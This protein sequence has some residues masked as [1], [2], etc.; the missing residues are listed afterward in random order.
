MLKMFFL[1]FIFFVFFSGQSFCYEIRL[2]NQQEIQSYNYK[3]A[4]LVIDVFRD[5]PHFYDG[6]LEDEKQHLDQYFLSKNATIVVAEKNHELIGAI[7]GI[8]LGETFSNCQSFFK[9]HNIETRDMFYLGEIALKK[10]H[11]GQGLGS[12][13]YALFEEVIK[14]KTAYKQIVLCKLVMKNKHP[15]GSNHYFC[16]DNF[17]SKRDYVEQPNWLVQFPWKEVTTQEEIDHPMIFWSKQL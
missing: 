3:L 15:D 1:A 10:E 17:W 16:L 5:Y 7:A 8:P 2:L 4:S 14:N 6:E 13:M 11:R 12:R 9:S